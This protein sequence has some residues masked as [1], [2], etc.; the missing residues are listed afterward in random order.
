MTTTIL[1]YIMYTLIEDWTKIKL[2]ELK[3]FGIFPKRHCTECSK[4]SVKISVSV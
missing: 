4:L 1:N 2:S 3:M